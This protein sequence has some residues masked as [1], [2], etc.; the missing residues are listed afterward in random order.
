ME[1]E[2]RKPD[3]V[4]KIDC[5]AWVSKTKDGKDY[6]NVKLGNFL[7]INLFRNEPQIKVDEEKV[8]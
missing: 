8:N 5:A 7:V 6:I 4:G 2:K 1:N 3:F